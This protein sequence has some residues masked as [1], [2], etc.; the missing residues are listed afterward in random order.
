M[1]LTMHFIS[2]SEFKNKRYKRVLAGGSVQNNSYPNFDEHFYEG[3]TL[4][5]SIEAEN[6]FPCVI[7]YE[8]NSGAKKYLEIRKI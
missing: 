3:K 8:E 5:E 7:C 2:E 6:I 1:E 4:R